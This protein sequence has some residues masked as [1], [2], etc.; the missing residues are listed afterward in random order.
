VLPAKLDLPSLCVIPETD[1]I[2][3]PESALALGQA[4]PGAELLRPPLGHI[5]MVASGRAQELAWQPLAA[6]LRERG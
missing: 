4:I 1:R 3:P 6:W 2:V 5:G